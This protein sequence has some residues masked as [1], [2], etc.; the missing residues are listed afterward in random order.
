MQRKKIAIANRGEVAV[1]IHRACKEL[2]YDTLLLHSEPDKHSIA[3]RLC[4]ETHC[5]G[6]GPAAESYINIDKVI[7]GAK[8]CGASALHPGFGF[9]S[10]NGDFASKCAENNIT[11]IGPSPESMFLFGDKIKAKEFCE[12]QKVPT[13][14]SY[15]G[16]DQSLET[17][18]SEA[19]KIG[20]PVLVK[21]AAGGGG[22]GM[23][24]IQEESKLKEGLESA[25]NEALKAFGSEQVF[26]EKYL[27]TSKHIEVQIFG[28]CEGEVH[29]LG[30]RECSVQR[31]HQKIIEEALSPSLNE[32][33]R[34]AV[35]GYAQTLCS[36]SNY[37]NAGTVEF[38]FSEGQFYFLE[39]NT[40]LQVE[41]PVT[42]EVF[43]IDLVQAQIKTAFKEP[44]SLSSK[45]KNLHSIE[46][47][48]YAEDLK[49]FP[50]IGTIGTIDLNHTYSKD[51]RLELGFETG[52]TVSPFY[53]SMIAK[54]IFTAPDRN[55]C[56]H[57]A[58]NHLKSTRV[59]GLQTNIPLLIEI[60]DH[61]DFRS[62]TMNTKFFETHFSEGLK[63]LY[64]E[65]ELLKLIKENK[66]KS[67]T[68][69][70]NKNWSV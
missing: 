41:H 30:E 40:R 6:Q 51:V 8:K 31:R 13:L 2:G 48:I 37:Q 56:I 35:Y 49:G 70:F 69:L 27:E 57:K 53:D 11:F 65:A 26:L 54:L 55:S 1:R 10:E 32:D 7:A 34:A 46:C 15:R 14:Q 23:R 60:L 3:Y 42:E 63:P 28:D 22:R 45:P 52:D 24:I 68:S 17:L 58:L 20:Y 67:S 66:I 43:G 16:S 33:L 62:G 19:K 25:K 50:S 18:K 61:K 36:N 4:D 64:N 5:I 39:V 12:S 47:R 29:V 44:I 9:L 59:T 21:A 38:L